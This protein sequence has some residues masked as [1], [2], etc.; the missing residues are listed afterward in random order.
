LG[1]FGIDTFY[2]KTKIRIEKIDL[3]CGFYILGLLISSGLD[4]TFKLILIAT[5]PLLL[6]NFEIGVKKKTLIYI[7]SSGILFVYFRTIY[8][9]S[10]SLRM[11][12]S[13]IRRYA[14]MD[15]AVYTSI[16]V[17]LLVAG[18]LLSI[19]WFKRNKFLALWTSISALGSLTLLLLT[20][21]RAI[22]L[23]LIGA[24]IVVILALRNKKAIGILLAATLIGG[25][26]AWIAREKI[27]VLQRFKEIDVSPIQ[28]GE[29]VEGGK[30]TRYEAYT[31]G[32]KIF[33]EHP[34]KGVGI[35]NYSSNEKV[36]EY[37]YRDTPYFHAHNIYIT[38][39]A[40][41]G[42]VGF[43]SVFLLFLY[44][45]GTT[46]RG[47]RKNREE[48]IL[49]YLMIFNMIF[50]VFD[51]SLGTIPMGILLI[52]YGM[53]KQGAFKLPV[54]FYLLNFHFHHKTPKYLYVPTVELNIPFL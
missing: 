47:T 50:G 53:I 25:S 34:V 12:F 27:P 42:V 15:F 1:I 22:L 5:L 44:I 32:I 9:M 13:S 20:H 45:L 46:F 26:G 41:T 10:G 4:G 48:S 21:Q 29:Y 18:I 17:S 6:R 3:L 14:I 33:L 35:K 28:N 8:Q 40:T 52:L 11:M 38:T 54:L 37:F 51:N 31:G 30:L 49:L 2:F 23:G 24:T 16:L 7:I 43:I 39:L 19:Y 36:E